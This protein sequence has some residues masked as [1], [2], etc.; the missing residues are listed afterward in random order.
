MANAAPTSQTDTPA[1]D[2]AAAGAFVSAEVLPGG[3]AGLEAYRSFCSNACFAPP[4]SPLWAEAWLSGDGRDGLV[5]ILRRAGVP[6]MAIALEIVAQ[7][8]LR[9]ARFPGGQHANGNFPALHASWSGTAEHEAGVRALLV[10][11]RRARPRIDMLSLERQQRSFQGRTNPMFVLPHTASPNLSLAADLSGGMD[12]I[13]DGSGGATKQKRH[14]K[15][16]RKLEAAGGCRRFAATSE[17]EVDALLDLFFSLKRARLA[18]IGVPDIFGPARVRESFR[19]LFL[20]A[21]KEPEPPF[22]LHA[23]EAGGKV[24]AITGSSRTADAIICEFSTFAEDELAAASPGEFLFYE[25]IAEA[26]G[27]NL[28]LYDFSVGDEPYKRAWCDVETTHFDAFVG[29]T[30]QGRLAAAGSFALAAMKR[31]IKQN[32]MT[33]GIAKKA[34]QFSAV[35]FNR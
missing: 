18:R 7:G 1:K 9:F 11:I 8:P 34:R 20:S 35:S 25:N 14:R 23:L 17:N 24:R 3:P 22:V 5:A 29:L 33:A 30:P 19:R 26:C 31:L 12:K 28:S 16:A 32:A 10:A 4:Q 6:A 21:L 27:E 13:L 2:P 15:Q